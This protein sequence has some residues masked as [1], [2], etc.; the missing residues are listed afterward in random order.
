MASLGT[1]ELY[2][3]F[4]KSQACVPH[5]VGNH[6]WMLIKSHSTKPRGSRCLQWAGCLGDT[7]RALYLGS[8]PEFS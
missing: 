2:R 6:Q 4:R 5:S 8:R 1:K 3:I 7:A